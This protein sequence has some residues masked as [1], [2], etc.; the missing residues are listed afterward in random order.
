[1][2]I[3][4]ALIV[5]VWLALVVGALA[6][7]FAEASLPGG[8]VQGLASAPMVWAFSFYLAVGCARGFTFMPLTVLIG[9]GMLFLRPVPLFVLTMIG[10]LISSAGIYY[11]ASVLDVYEDLQR[12]KKKYVDVL[13][14]GL[15]KFELPIIVGW[16]LCPILPTDLVCCVSGIM[17]L[18]LPKLLLGI[19]IGEGICCALY[20]FYGEQMIAWFG[21]AR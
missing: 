11:F 17:K 3:R 6:F 21:F 15:K 1:M 9:F 19:L 8:G 20:I 14:S 13:E 10:T 5:F 7:R 4:K 2:S 12:K 18:S 16:S